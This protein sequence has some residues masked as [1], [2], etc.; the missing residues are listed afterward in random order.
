MNSSNAVQRVLNG[1]KPSGTLKKDEKK[2]KK[3]KEKDKEQK[4]VGQFSRDLYRGK[5]VLQR[6]WKN[7][8]C[9][10]CCH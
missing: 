7:L 1:E 6:A 3:E 9:K 8:L 5:T 10:D 2:K 4:Q